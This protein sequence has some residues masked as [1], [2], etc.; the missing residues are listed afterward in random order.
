MKV[1]LTIVYI[2]LTLSV[3]SQ[4]K[5]KLKVIET[6]IETF[7]ITDSGQPESDKTWTVSTQTKIDIYE[8]D[9]ILSNHNVVTFYT[10]KETF[11]V[12]VSLKKPV[13][14]FII[15]YK[16]DSCY[17]R[18]HFNQVPDYLDTLRKGNK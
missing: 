15:L 18:V 12:K 17:T 16:G 7:K 9:G 11:E 4:N 13:F 14:D 2:A 6:G 5:T 8:A 10:D 3:F 1:Y